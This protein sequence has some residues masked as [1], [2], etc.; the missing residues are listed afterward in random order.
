MAK[1]NTSAVN[2]SF[3]LVVQLLFTLFQTIY[4]VAATTGDLLV[5]LRLYFE[6]GTL[7]VASWSIPVDQ[8]NLKSSHELLC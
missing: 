2:I 5:S 3:R 8:S 6:I 1:G 7:A 4:P